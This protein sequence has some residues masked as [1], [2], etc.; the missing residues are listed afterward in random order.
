[1]KYTSRITNKKYALIAAY[2]YAVAKARRQFKRPA[3]ED[4]PYKRGELG[5]SVVATAIKE[6]YGRIMPR[7]ERKQLAKATGRPMTKFYAQG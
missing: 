2:D 6:H 1:M 7:R 4:K 5:P 3:N